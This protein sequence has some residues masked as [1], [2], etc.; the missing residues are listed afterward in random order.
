MPQSS[1]SAVFTQLAACLHSLHDAI[2]GERHRETFVTHSHFTSTETLHK[3]SLTLPPCCDCRSIPTSPVLYTVNIQ[4]LQCIVYH[5]EL[6]N[7]SI[8]QSAL[9]EKSH[10][11]THIQ[12]SGN[13]WCRLLFAVRCCFCGH[14]NNYK[15]IKLYNIYIMGKSTID[16]HRL[17]PNQ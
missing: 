11:C 2:K 4:R 6:P 3:D 7:G 8:I 15:P 1:T 5:T 13:V 9:T 16:H 17:H 14:N 12:Q 10:F